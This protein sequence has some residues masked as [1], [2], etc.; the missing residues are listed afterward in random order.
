MTLTEEIAKHPK[1][2]LSQCH[3][4]HH[5]CHT[6]Q[7]GFETSPLPGEVGVGLPEPK[8]G[9]PGYKLKHNMNI[10]Y[11]NSIARTAQTRVVR[12]LLLLASPNVDSLEWHHV[13]NMF[14]K[15]K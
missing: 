10:S 12:L 8:Q 1:K 2:S 4:A 14:Y 6:D 9:L 15:T 3:L 5:K 13:H 11:M 7:S